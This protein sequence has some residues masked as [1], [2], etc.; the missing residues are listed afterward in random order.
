MSF[1][2]VSKVFSQFNFLKWAR[3]EITA[4]VQILRSQ[5]NP[6]TTDPKLDTLCRKNLLRTPNR[7][8]QKQ[9]T[10]PISLRMLD[11]S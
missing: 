8:S 3:W 5:I 9:V 7:W 4:R 11:F 10:N 2:L 1:I 6:P